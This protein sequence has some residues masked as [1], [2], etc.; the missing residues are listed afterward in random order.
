[1]KKDYYKILD[2]SPSD[3]P[4]RI[5]EQY[6]FFAHAWHPDKF[7]APAQKAKA[8]ERM[9]EINEAYEV[10]SDAAKKAQYD[11]EWHGQQQDTEESVRE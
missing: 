1:M 4:K 2:V 3:S 6:L 10:L 7:P 5:K 9:K 8:E 11:K